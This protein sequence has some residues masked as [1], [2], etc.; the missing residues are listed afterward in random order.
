MPEDV[1][2]LGV[3][4]IELTPTEEVTLRFVCQGYSNVRIANVRDITESGVERLLTRLR[5]KLGIRG[6]GCPARIELINIVWNAAWKNA[7]IKV[8]V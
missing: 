5:A 1:F 4:D 8:T 3:R 6:G 7:G 2:F